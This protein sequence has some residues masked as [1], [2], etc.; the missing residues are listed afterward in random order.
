MASNHELQARYATLVD[1]KLR[2]S[3]VKKPG[4]FW[5]TRYEGNPKAGMVKI[6]VR[7]AEVAIKT[8]DRNNGADMTF[9]ATSYLDMPINKEYAVNEPP[10]AWKAQPPPWAIPP[11]SPPRP[12]TA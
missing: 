8:Y 2:A 1:K 11:P 9:G 6:P 3:L 12:S 4:I 10:P 7:D 5:N